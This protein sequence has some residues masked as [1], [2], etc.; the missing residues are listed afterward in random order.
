[1]S[2]RVICADVEL[3]GVVQS[4]VD[5]A[6]LGEELEVQRHS[7]APAGMVVVEG[8]AHSWELIT[9]SYAGLHLLLR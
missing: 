7:W 4:E 8:D 5:K 3:A 1:M 2:K 9:R 6:G